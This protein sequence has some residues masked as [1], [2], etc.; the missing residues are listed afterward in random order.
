VCSSDLDDIVSPSNADCLGICIQILHAA[1][2]DELAAGIADTIR[3]VLTAEELDEDEM[4]IVTKSLAAVFR[5]KDTET[6]DQVV[7]MIGAPLREAHLEDLGP[8]WLTVW[9]GLDSYKEKERAWPH[10]VNELLLGLRWEDPRQKIEFYQALSEINTTER[11]DLLVKTESLRAL[12]EKELAKDIFHAPAPLLYNLHEMLL[13]SSLADTH[14][15]LL[16]QRLSYQKAHPL[17]TIMVE[18]F[19][20]YNN[21]HRA[22]YQAI[23]EQGLHEKIVPSLRDIAARHFKGALNRLPAERRDEVWVDEAIIWLGRLSEGSAD[24]VLNR[25]LNEKKFFFFPVWPAHCRNAARDALAGAQRA[26]E[27]NHHGN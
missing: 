2:T 24:S 20:D 23:L 11:I 1:P 6:T 21:A 9:Q 27:R 13:N 3:T 10:L 14:G 26:S 15:P 7:A 17:A 5:S 16:Q 18:G 12:Q 4:R 19:G 22:A 8:L 25:I